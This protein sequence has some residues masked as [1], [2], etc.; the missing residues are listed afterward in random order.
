ME[1][2]EDSSSDNDRSI[3]IHDVDFDQ[4]VAHLSSSMQ[5]VK[6]NAD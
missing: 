1:G 2:L 6:I 4:L 3:I 5:D